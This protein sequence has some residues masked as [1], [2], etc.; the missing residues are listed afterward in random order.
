MAIPPQGHA[1]AGAQQAPLTVLLVE[2]D[3]LIR[4]H[5]TDMLRELGHRVIEAEYGPDALA[6]LQAEPVDV[7]VTD[8]GLPGM[9]G[10]ML[11]TRARDVQPGI[12]VVFATGHDELPPDERAE[13]ADAVLLLK[14]YDA[15]GLADSLRRALPVRA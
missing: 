1:P 13:H 11:A 6:V 2:D 4:A 14:P 7:L 5:A 12:G 8:V 15:A 10:P 3:L 9:S